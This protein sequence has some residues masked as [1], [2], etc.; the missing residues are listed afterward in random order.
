M[1]ETKLGLETFSVWCCLGSFDLGKKNKPGRS[2]KIPYSGGQL[3]DSTL[4]NAKRTILFLWG[5]S[6]QS[7]I[8]QNRHTTDVSRRLKK[9]D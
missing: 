4:H 9:R 8:P 2:Q 5:A 7:T 6:R 1:K 3:I